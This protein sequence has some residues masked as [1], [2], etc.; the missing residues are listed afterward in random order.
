MER[1]SLQAEYIRFGLGIG[2][3]RVI[4]IEDSNSAFTL[5]KKPFCFQIPILNG[6]M[7]IVVTEDNNSCCM[8]NN[9]DDLVYVVD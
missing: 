9:W 3:G 8:D 2:N 4:W 7:W 6:R 5:Q 1:E